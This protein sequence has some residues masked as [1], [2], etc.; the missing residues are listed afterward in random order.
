MYTYVAQL[1]IQEYPVFT[2]SHINGEDAVF[3]CHVT[4]YKMVTV[5]WTKD[6]TVLETDHRISTNV[7]EVV[8]PDDTITLT[9]QLTIT[10]LILDDSGMYSCVASSSYYDGNVTQDIALLM[11]EG[12]A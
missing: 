2:V 11:V 3:T 10:D 4:G 8:S 1:V 12:K 6:N 9:S 7:T 5:T